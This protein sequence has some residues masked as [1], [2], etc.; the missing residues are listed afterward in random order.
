MK[1]TVFCGSSSGDNELFT[2]QAH[3][4]GEAL[5]KRNISLIYGGAKVGLMGAVADGALSNNGEVIGVIPH[6]LANVE[7]EHQGLSSLIKVETMHERKALMDKLCDGMI[8]MPGGFGTMEELFEVLT[9]G[10]LG[11]HKKPVA[12]FNINGFYDAL[13][14]MID[15]MVDRKFLKTENRSMILV[16]DNIEELLDL[17]KNYKAPTEGKWIKKE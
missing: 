1:Y 8:A 17:M 15:E 10:Q 6:F 14:Q 4:L 3:Q 5:A 7:I 9:W 16:S 2:T 11:L 13:L 12:L